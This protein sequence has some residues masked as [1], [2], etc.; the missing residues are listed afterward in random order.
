[1]QDGDFQPLD[2]QSDKPIESSAQAPPLSITQRSAIGAHNDIA[3]MQRQG[4]TPSQDQYFERFTKRYE[5]E[6]KAKQDIAMEEYRKNLELQ[7]QKQMEQIRLKG[8]AEKMAY[9]KELEFQQKAAEATTLP[10]KETPEQMDK[11]IAATNA[12]DIIM[13]MHHSY[14][15]AAKKVPATG[16]A[17]FGGATNWWNVATNKEARVF[18]QLKNINAVSLARGLYE[19][20]GTQAGREDMLKKIDASLP[21]PGDSPEMGTIKTVSLLQTNLDRMRNRIEYLQK[22]R[23]DT[24]A[25][26][27]AYKS[28]YANYQNL[29]P[30]GTDA[31]RGYPSTSPD[32]LFKPRVPQVQP[33]VKAGVSNATHAVLD[34]GA[35]AGIQMPQQE[36]AYSQTAAMPRQMPAPA[37]MPQPTGPPLPADAAAAVNGTQPQKTGFYGQ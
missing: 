28:T 6:F 17:F 36:E 3:E 7:N 4:G 1:M 10:Q 30:Q 16:Y 8:E 2:Q 9:G 23:Y 15:D 29:L 21:S 18:D 14:Q 5:D 25:L 34:A 22:N 20:T 27:Q 37:Q 24:S 31:Q 26:Q 12:G 32:D 13:Q 33:V 35:N 19:D 11:D